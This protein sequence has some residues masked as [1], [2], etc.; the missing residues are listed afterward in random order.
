MIPTSFLVTLT[1]HQP[2]QP[3]HINSNSKSVE[4]SGK[5]YQAVVRRLVAL[6][7]THA[8]VLVFWLRSVALLPQT[9]SLSAPYSETSRRTNPK[10]L[11]Y[12][13]KVFLRFY[14]SIGKLTTFQLY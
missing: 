13:T 2:P 9:P 1:K 4:H 7:S 3:Q 10:A 12:I 5:P 14:G 6:R 11:V 8:G